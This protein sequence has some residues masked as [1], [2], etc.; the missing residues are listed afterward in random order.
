[1]INLNLETASY[2]QIKIYKEAWLKNG[3]RID[4]DSN[5]D[6]KGKSWCRHNLQR[7]N[8]SFEP[9][10]SSNEH[11]FIFEQEDVAQRFMIDMN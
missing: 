11:T 2:D 1:M 9:F 4:V 8:W 3:H 7:W 10:T 5:L 6:V